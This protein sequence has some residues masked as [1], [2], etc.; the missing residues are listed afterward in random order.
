ML[1]SGVRQNQQ[2]GYSGSGAAVALS[3]AL[4]GCSASVVSPAGDEITSVG[5]TVPYTPPTDYAGPVSSL[6]VDP[7][8]TVWE[9]MTATPSSV[10]DVGFNGWACELLL[11]KPA[12]PGAWRLVGVTEAYRPIL[13][14][15]ADRTGMPVS[16]NNVYYHFRLHTDEE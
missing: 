10:P 14:I 16:S 5:L 4:C 6:V 3:L 12:Q 1:R 13:D 9:Q 7:D 11:P 8:L 2:A 15:V